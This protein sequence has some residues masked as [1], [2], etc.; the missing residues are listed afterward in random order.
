MV[1]PQTS[2][3]PAPLDGPGRVAQLHSI[4]LGNLPTSAAYWR[5]IL[6]LTTKLKSE[7]EHQRRQFTTRAPLYSDF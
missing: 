1:G 7:L 6:I 3:G 5:L 4:Q 2:W